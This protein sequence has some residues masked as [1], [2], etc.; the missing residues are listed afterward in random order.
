MPPGSQVNF[1]VLGLDGWV[2]N[3]NRIPEFFELFNHLKMFLVLDCR[4]QM[5]SLS[6]I[7]SDIHL[8]GSSP[9][10]RQA[11]R[12]SLTEDGSCR[13]WV[14]TSVRYWQSC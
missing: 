3:Y 9:T 10:L 14:S 4:A 1:L 7:T 5:V 13:T 11:D 12:R 8:W 2:S 6:D